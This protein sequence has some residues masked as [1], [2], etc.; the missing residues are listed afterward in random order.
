M[1]VSA[2]SGRRVVGIAVVGCYVFLA[3]LLDGLADVVSWLR[4]AR[5][6]SL[7]RW[8]LGGD[9]LGAGLDPV[10]VLVLA[11]VGAVAV[12]VGAWGFRR[13]DLHA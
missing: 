7:W 1:A 10:A 2:G 9:P 8:Y 4:P 3:Y 6:L 12:V 5:S 11:A 13:R